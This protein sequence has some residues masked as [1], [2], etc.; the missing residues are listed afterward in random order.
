V[1]GS[2]RLG[3]LRPAAHTS[4]FDAMLRNHS[5]NRI[6]FLLLALFVLA[7]VLPI[8]GCQ[9]D[10]VRAQSDPPQTSDA[11]QQDQST[12]TIQNESDLPETSPGARY[13]VQLVALGGGAPYHW[14]LEGGTLP[15]GIKL[16][17]H[18]VLTG[19]ADHAGE[20]QFSLSVRDSLGHTVRK[21]F[22]IR[23]RSAL[24]LNWK[25]PARV[26]GNRIEG[27]VEVLNTTADDIDLTFVVMAV[28]TM[29]SRGTA[30]GYQHFVL[31]KGGKP[32]VLPFGETLPRGEYIVHVDTVGEVAPKKI[33]YRERLQTP[34]LQVNVGP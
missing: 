27:T 15:P 21:P 19:A 6:A 3:Q 10:V 14:N 31:G 29:D 2:Q 13:E 22:V 23:V 16:I 11:A 25:D 33:I 1:F 30:I 9:F 7:L 34:A 28:A 17:E 12:L 18:G 20:F 5:L 32:K 4:G 24:M 26:N 8:S